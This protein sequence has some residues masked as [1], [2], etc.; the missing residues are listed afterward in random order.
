M[1][2][3]QN[4][5]KVLVACG[6]ALALVS[7][8][9]AQEVKQIS[10]KVVRVKG[11]ARYSTDGKV[12]HPLTVGTLLKAGAVVQTAASSTADIVL[13][14]TEAAGTGLTL[15]KAAA[16]Q[17]QAQKIAYQPEAQQNI[18]RMWEDSVLGIDKLTKTQT[19]ADVVTDTQ[20]DLRAG[21]IFGTVRKLSSTS[22]YEVKIPNGVAG[23]RGTIYMISAEGVVSVLEGTVIIAYVKADGTVV[24]QEVQAGYQYDARTGQISP[25][26]PAT[27]E[28][29]ETGRTETPVISVQQTPTLYVQP[30]V[31]ASPKIGLTPPAP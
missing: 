29:M 13:D 30:E 9:V 5:M 18:V 4:L 10:A 6:I 27:R 16:Y 11:N 2:Q 20:L 24:T 14:E 28:S 21:R 17:P 1:K 15:G 7:N 26:P 25:L 31:Y 22:K 12:W 8:A 23:I 19:G 3:I